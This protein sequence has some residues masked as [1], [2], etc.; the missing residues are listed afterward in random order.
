M[1]NDLA[2]ANGEWHGGECFL[3]LAAAIHIGHFT[4]KERSTQN[5][6]QTVADERHSEHQLGKR[7]LQGESIPSGMTMNT[8][9]M[10][11]ALVLYTEYTDTPSLQNKKQ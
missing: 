1:V 11:P 7:L 8:E 6:E 9:P 2:N 3:A 4:H 5:R 10:P